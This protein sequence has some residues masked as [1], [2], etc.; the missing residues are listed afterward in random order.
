MSSTEK[1]EIIKEKRKESDSY[2]LNG[3]MYARFDDKKK[4][5]E[6]KEDQFLNINSEQNG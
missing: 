5:R 6:R 1:K 4:K 2:C 3:E